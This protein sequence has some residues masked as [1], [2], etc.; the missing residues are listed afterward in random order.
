MSSPVVEVN[1]VTNSAFRDFP[2]GTVTSRVGFDTVLFDSGRAA[3]PTGSRV[4]DSVFLP[5]W[6][7]DRPLSLSVPQALVSPLA[8]NGGFN[9][10]GMFLNAQTIGG[11]TYVGLCG[12][13]G[14]PRRSH[15][16][17]AGT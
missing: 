17:S 8:A 1:S 2:G 13:C 9:T 16:S 6:G 3:P 4:H 7:D 14:W 12:R 10:G 5:D 15:D 11:S